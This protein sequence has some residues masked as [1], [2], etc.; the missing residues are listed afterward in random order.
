MFLQCP[1]SITRTLS[2][3]IKVYS[4]S[5]DKF[6]LY[7]AR[8]YSVRATYFQL[9]VEDTSIFVLSLSS[10]IAPTRFC[11]LNVINIYFRNLPYLFVIRMFRYFIFFNVI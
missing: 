1:A 6:T 4:N 3:H 5:I 11:H 10:L 7:I 8:M 9:Y 2:Y